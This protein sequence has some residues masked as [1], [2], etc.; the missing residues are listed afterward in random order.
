MWAARASKIGSDWPVRY[1][2]R[3]QLTPTWT[4]SL[5]SHLRIEFWLIKR[6]LCCLFASILLWLWPA[7]PAVCY[8]SCHLLNLLFMS[9]SWMWLSPVVKSLAI[10][11]GSSIFGL[12]LCSLR[13]DSAYTCLSSVT[14]L[15][16]WLTHTQKE[17]AAKSKQGNYTVIHHLDSW[18]VSC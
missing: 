15:H 1:K 17:V 4:W 18:V 9:L 11:E 7:N 14:I 2:I 3:H 16:T 10:L 6:I 5:S 13:E 12:I 8:L